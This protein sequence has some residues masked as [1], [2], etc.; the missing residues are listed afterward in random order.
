MPVPT[1]VVRA[2]DS[3][4]KGR[5]S[6]EVTREQIDYLNYGRVMDTPRMRTEL[7]FEPKWTTLEAFDDFVRG[8][9]LAPIINPDWVRL[10]EGRAL[11]VAQRWGATSV[12]QGR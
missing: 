10:L 12:G 9:G 1:F 4:G 2:A 5:L 3:V 7:G 11:A 8:W 6:S